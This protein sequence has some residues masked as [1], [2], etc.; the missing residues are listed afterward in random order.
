[1]SRALERIWLATTLF[2]LA[3]FT[4]AGCTTTGRMSAGSG[5]SGDGS[6]QMGTSRSEIIPARESARESGWSGG[7]SSIEGFVSNPDLQEIYF[8]FDKSI[9]TDE[10]ITTLNRHADWAKKSASALLLIEGHADERGTNEYNLAL[11][12]RRAKAAR[13]FLVSLGISSSR[14]SQ[15]S[16]GE[17]RPAC[18]ES[19]E[20][21]WAKN[22]R[23]H[24]LVKMR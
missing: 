2:F 11:G 20:A 12:E 9:L 6:S 5:E 1:M 4:L 3:A 16:Y 8:A 13:D 24:F 23:D 17:E 15:I 14:V 22:R 21:C 7:G 19:T 10:G 18:G